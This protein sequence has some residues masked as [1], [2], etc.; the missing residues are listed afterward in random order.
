MR[1]AVVTEVGSPPTVRDDQTEPAREPA[2]AI[3][4]VAAASLNPV[5]TR[6]AAGRFAREA[7]PPYVPGLEGAGLVVE[8]DGMEAGTRVR[9]ES[10]ALPGFGQDGVLAEL[11]A[12]P[13][14]SLVELPD[15]VNEAVAA[16]IGVV[17]ITAWAAL[18]RAG[19]EEG[20]RVLVLGATGAVGQMAVQLSK[21]LGAQRVVAAGRDTE[22]L[23][24]TRSLGADETVELSD[25][26]KLEEVYRDAAGG[27]LDVVVDPLWGAPA[28]A[29]L[30]S[31]ETGGRL[32][33]VGESAGTDVTL[34]LAQI[35]REQGSILTLSSG[36]MPLDAKVRAYR[37]VLEHAAA[38]RIEVEHE[39][40]P[41]DQVTEAWERQA[42]SPGRKL[43][44]RTT[45]DAVET[46]P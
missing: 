27:G 45:E 6:V 39:V 29:A 37:Q 10:A 34:P 16:A 40:V 3:V 44:V 17:G 4:R 22:R 7:E 30:S 8:A 15:E 38:G 36:W 23:E 32:V 14:E 20:E 46:A 21:L 11:A 12:V 43:V 41:L 35:R 33:N 28:M 25:G 5:E 19:V 24:R 13:A 18:E 9:F 42:R 2:T 31:L 26:R 1:A